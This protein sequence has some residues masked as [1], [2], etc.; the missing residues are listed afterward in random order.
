MPL[1]C[2]FLF[3][4]IFYSID[5]WHKFS[6]IF[7]KHSKETNM[8]A[9]TIRKIGGSLGVIL[10]VEVVDTLSVTEGDKVFLTKADGGYRI[11]THDPDF[12]ETMA[13]AEDIMK[14]YRN[15]LRELAK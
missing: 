11:T 1:R 8:T 12:E 2:P 15:T 4:S 3:K 10:P 14:R 7:I 6:Y 5:F 9:L 13:A